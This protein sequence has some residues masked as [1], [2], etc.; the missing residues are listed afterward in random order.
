[1]FHTVCNFFIRVA[2]VFLLWCHSSI[3][4]HHHRH[5]T[6]PSLSPSSPSHHS[7]HHHHIQP[8]SS[9]QQ[10]RPQSLTL[11]RAVRLAYRWQKA[12]SEKEAIEGKLERTKLKAEA[13]FMKLKCV[14]LRTLTDDAP[15]LLSLSDV[16]IGPAQTTHP[17]SLSHSEDR[18]CTDS[19]TYCCVA[20][21]GRWPAQVALSLLNS[22][23]FF[24]S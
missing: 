7:R 4:V 17:F 23:D 9:L 11:L 8:S 10:P 6:Q 22:Q 2:R 19:A 14:R 5:L 16:G 13:K 20:P 12:S 1:M 3:P 18:V 21:T 24:A 15:L